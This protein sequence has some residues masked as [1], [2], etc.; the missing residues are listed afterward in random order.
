M[1][2]KKKDPNEVVHVQVK[3]GETVVYQGHLYG[4]RATLQVPRRYLVHVDGEYDEV[5]PDEVPDVG[6]GDGYAGEKDGPK[7]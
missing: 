1:A 6:K 7:E 4:D 5:K 3:P 2:A